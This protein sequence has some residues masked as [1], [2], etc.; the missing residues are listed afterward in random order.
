MKRIL[1]YLF[2]LAATIGSAAKTLTIAEA[3]KKLRLAEQIILNY[4]VDELDNDEVVTEAIRSMLSTLDPHSAYT[5]PKETEEL[6]KPLEGK[7]SGIGVAFNLISD[8]VYVVS[9]VAG[10]PSERVG[11]QAGDRIIMAGDSSLVGRDRTAVMGFL[12]GDKGSKVDLKIRRGKEDI[13]FRVTR[14]DIPIHSVDAA[15]MADPTTGYIRISRFAEDT[16]NEVLEALVKLDKKGMKNLIIDLQDNTGG[17]LGSAYELAEIFLHK[18]D[19]VV[20]TKGS[21][22]KPM[23]YD[24]QRD[25][26]MTEGRLVIL[27]NQFSA[28]ASEILAGAIQ[29]NDRG[30]IVGRRT[31]GKGLV[32]RPFPMPDGSMIRL[33]TARYYTP[34]GRCIQKPYT[35]GRRDDYDHDIIDR[36][37]NGELTNADSLRE[38]PDSLR[39]STLRNKRA[40]YGG[41]GIQ[42]DLFVPLDTVSRTDYYRDLVAKGVINQYTLSYVDNNR[43]ELKKKYKNED[44]F[45][46]S[47]EVTDDMIEQ[48]VA[49]GEQDSIVCNREQLAISLPTIKCVVKGLIMRDIFDDSSYYRVAN[50][51]SDIF[52]RGFELINNKEEYE[53]LL[54]GQ[55]QTH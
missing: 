16:A 15:Y 42:P 44:K 7:F 43:A 54:S 38:M 49:R 13:I 46:K 26:L 48:L 41:G 8:S 32:Q 30:L 45:L 9:T 5:D 33:T 52:N 39:F 53:R 17:Y 35:K 14:D 18:G 29:D 19:P 37:N 1:I 55:Q 50:Q 40:V 3:D 47:F 11:I 23:N 4:Y 25:G 22:V 31:F 27:V 6:T 51:I 36:F 24:T 28:S 34:S 10:G 2:V 12:R 20:S 21:R